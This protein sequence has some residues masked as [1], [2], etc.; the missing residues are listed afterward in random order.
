MNVLLESSDLSQCSPATI[1]RCAVIY[2]RR[3]SLPLKAHINHWLKKLPTILNDERVNKECMKK[4]DN[5]INFFLRDIFSR[6]IKPEKL[7]YKIS[8]EWAVLN[9]LRLLEA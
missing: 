6:Y 7:L 4:L 2:L 3:E 8:S 5:Y 1:T 9:F